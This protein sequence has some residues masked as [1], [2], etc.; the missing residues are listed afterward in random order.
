MMVREPVLISTVT[1]IP[2]PSLTLIYLHGRDDHQCIKPLSANVPKPI[3]P[4]F[5]DPM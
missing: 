2:G 5:P 1:A 3:A 4:I